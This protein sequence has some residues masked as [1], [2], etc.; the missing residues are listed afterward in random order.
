LRGII[1]GLVGAVLGC[2][3]GWWIASLGYMGVT[4]SVQGHNFDWL[5]HI[6]LVVTG[7]IFGA[8]TMV[9][10]ASVIAFRERPGDTRRVDPTHGHTGLEI[11]W[12]VI[13]LIIVSVFS[14]LAWKTLRDNNKGAHPWHIVVTAMKW[15]FNY[16]YREQGLMSHQLVLPIGQPVQFEVESVDIIHG[17]WVPAWRVQ[18]NATPGQV[19]LLDVTPD[20]LG[21]YT[22]ECNFIC[23]TGHPTMNSEVTGGSV[24]P[25]LVLT[26]PA[27]DSWLA[28]QQAKQRQ[29]AASPTGRA[30]AVFAANGC[31]SCHTWSKAGTNGAIGPNLDNVAADAAKANRGSVAAYVRESIVNPGAYIVPGYQNLM[32]PGFGSRIPPADLNALVAALAGGAK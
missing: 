8:V 19:N 5:Y 22:V 27:F 18:M 25:V 20:R 3:L 16:R 9:L 14:G 29:L 7:G 21:S 10:I 26:R 4:A 23:G 30:V 32:P 13:P 11:T 15:E 12:T 28:Q 17:F 31:G 24:V 6:M 1:L 2:L